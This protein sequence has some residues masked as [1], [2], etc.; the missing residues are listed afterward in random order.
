M[1][2]SPNPEALQEWIAERDINRRDILKAIALF[3]GSGWLFRNQLPTA[4]NTN[5]RLTEAEKSAAMAAERLGVTDLRDP[6]MMSGLTPTLERTIETVNEVIHDRTVTQGVWIAEKQRQLTSTFSSIP[7][8]ASPPTESRPAKRLARL[9]AVLTY[10]QSLND[11]LQHVASTQRVLATIEIP[12]LYDRERPEQAPSSLVDTDAI[13]T[14][15]EEA[16]SAGERAASKEPADTLLPETE[17]VATQ[18]SMQIRIQ[19]QHSTAIQSY[20]DSADR[21]ETGARKHEQGHL[22]QAKSQFRAAKEAIPDDILESELTYAISTQGPTLRDYATHFT[23][24]RQG[25]NQ[26]IAACKSEIDSS[27]QNSRFNKGLTH[28]ID[29]RGVVSP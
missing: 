2:E 16:R 11:V 6:L 12:A 27:T 19:H 15:N 14:A 8:I 25:V 5:T 20:L 3:T 1:D 24:R 13:E 10:Y 29:A 7:G 28:L 17:Q 18:I 22:N 23:K 21:F 26:L 4:E 9:K